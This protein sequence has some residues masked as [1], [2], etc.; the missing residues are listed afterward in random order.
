LVLFVA[1]RDA[2]ARVG[3]IRGPS[4]ILTERTPLIND[5]T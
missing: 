4:G 1:I 5:P 3:V 2:R